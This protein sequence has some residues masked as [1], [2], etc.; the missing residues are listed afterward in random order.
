MVEAIQLFGRDQDRD[1]FEGRVVELVMQGKTPR[2]A[3]RQ[4]AR[5]H[6]SGR[7]PTG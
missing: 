3:E 2:A 6:L 1:W 5:E 4:A 7:K